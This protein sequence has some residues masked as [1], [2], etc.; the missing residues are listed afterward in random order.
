ITDDIREQT[1]QFILVN[2]TKP[3][4][5]G[6]I[7]E[8][9]P[10]TQGVLPT[11]LEK[12]RLPAYLLER[13][14]RDEESPLLFKVQSPTTPERVIKDNSI[15]RMWE[16]SLS[17]GVLFRLRAADDTSDDID[18]MLS[19]LRAFWGAVREVFAEAWGLPP[20]RSRLMHGAGVI[21]LGLLMDA[22]SDRYR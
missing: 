10:S 15:L 22:I 8:L 4:P 5:K 18:S 13:L 11:L 7:Y 2:S 16:N 12:R 14:N 19:A 3:L 21:T 1:E 9:L 17:D 6:L 20:R